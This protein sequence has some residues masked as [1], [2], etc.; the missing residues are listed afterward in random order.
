MIEFVVLQEI[1]SITNKPT[2]QS[3]RGLRDVATDDASDRR[4]LGSRGNMPNGVRAVIFTS[5][6]LNVLTLHGHNYKHIKPLQTLSKDFLMGP[7]I[8]ENHC[9][10]VESGVIC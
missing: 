9:G 10:L 7:P 5:L 6:F 3:R 2:A 4:W 1:A 8:Y